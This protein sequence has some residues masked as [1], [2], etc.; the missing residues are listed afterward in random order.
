MADALI[1]SVVQQGTFRSPNR[2]GFSGLSCHSAIP[3]TKGVIPKSSSSGSGVATI[4]NSN[5]KWPGFGLSGPAEAYQAWSF[6]G[7]FTMEMWLD[8][9]GTGANWQGVFGLG[10][11]TGGPTFYA[12]SPTTRK[13]QFYSSGVQLLHQNLTPSSGL[14]HVAFQR[15]SGALWIY[16][17]GVKSLTS[18]AWAGTISVPYPMLGAANQ[19]GQEWLR[20]VMYGY[21]VTNAARFTTD[22]DWTIEDIE[23]RNP[24][25]YNAVT[26][27]KFFDV[28]RFLQ[29]NS[30]G[31]PRGIHVP[32]AAIP[33]TGYLRRKMQYRTMALSWASGRDTIGLN[34]TV[35]IKGTPL[36]SPVARPVFLYSMSSKLPV[37]ATMSK[38]DGTYQ[39]RNLNPS[40]KYY[41]I[42]FDPTGFYRPVVADNL[43]T[44]ELPI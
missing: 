3:H 36:N 38:A 26:P 13:C 43:P 11:S 28:S 2:V 27:D 18:Y 22:F 29:K 17:N 6:T 8:L 9:N 20:G 33:T 7:D 12:D 1:A 16:L 25:S 21:R 37:G 40:D 42:A 4:I 15:V 30:V 23:E 44:Q 24:S 10:N 32:L 41:A 34:G 39:F 31:T 5:P 35:A 14:F 19:S